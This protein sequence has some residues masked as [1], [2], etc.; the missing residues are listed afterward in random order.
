[1]CGSV[2]EVRTCVGVCEVCTCVGVC[3]RCARTCVVCTSY[4]KCV[5][6]CTSHIMVVDEVEGVVCGRRREFGQLEE[7][8]ESFSVNSPV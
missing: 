1:M 3:V 6:V 4:I 2:C 8:R 7:E 5:Q